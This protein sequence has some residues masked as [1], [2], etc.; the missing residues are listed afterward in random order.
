MPSM[1]QDAMS[2][3][4]QG[5]PAHHSAGYHETATVSPI[6]E[7]FSKEATFKPRPKKL[8]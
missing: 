4:E 3:V 5:L 6:L 7:E 1:E 8:L 2:A